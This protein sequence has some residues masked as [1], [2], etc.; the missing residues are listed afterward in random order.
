MFRIEY[1]DAG[2]PVTLGEFRYLKQANEAAHKPAK[3][4]NIEM[5]K[6]LIALY[7]KNCYILDTRKGGKYI[8][9]WRDRKRSKL[10]R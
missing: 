5:P 6:D 3:L 1:I 10:W 7:R 8:P 9:I 4:F 2:K